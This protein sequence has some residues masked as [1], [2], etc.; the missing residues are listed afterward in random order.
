[1]HLETLNQ[2]TSSFDVLPFQVGMGQ[3]FSEAGEKVN[4]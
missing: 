4:S 3:S 1:M 2:D